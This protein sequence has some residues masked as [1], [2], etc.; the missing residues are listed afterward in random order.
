MN[1]KDIERRVGCF[2]IPKIIIEQYAGQV[3][4]IFQKM[5]VTRAEFCYH[6]A[7]VHY[8]AMSPIFDEV[9]ENEAPREYHIVF[10]EDGQGEV[11][12]MHIALAL[13]Q[14]SPSEQKKINFREF[15]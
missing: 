5:I 2:A 15:L 13:E 14:P 8:E 3:A 11:C 7:S 6:D 1:Y 12:R 10:H 4:N 9:G